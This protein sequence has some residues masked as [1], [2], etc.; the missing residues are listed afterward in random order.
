MCG[1][2]GV[3]SLSGE[4]IDVSVLQRMNDLQSHRGPDGE[5]FL[6]GWFDGETSSQVFVPQTAQHGHNNAVQVALGHRRLAILDLLD[7][8]L[9]PMATGDGRTWIVFNGEIYNHLELRAELE[10]SGYRFK[11][12]TDTEVLLTAYVHWGQDCLSRIEGMYAFAIWDGNQRRLF[13]ARDR[14]GIKPFYYALKDGFFIFASEI[15]ALLAFP[16][17]EAVAD[18]EAVLGFLTHG[19]CDYSERTMFRDIKALPGSHCIDID[20]SVDQFTPR[21][22]YQ[23]TPNTRYDLSDEDQ[24]GRLQE[25]LV[26]SVRKH[27]ISDVRIGS[28]L[29]GGLDSSAVV[30][31]VGKISRE[32][33]EAAGAIGDRLHTFT[34]CYEYKELD[35]RSFARSIADSVGAKS[36][37]VF[38]SASDFWADFERL[39][40]HQDMPCGSLSFYAQWRVMRAAKEAGVKVLLDGQGGDEVFGGYAKFRYAYMASLLRSGRLP[41]LSS[42]LYAMMR[43]GD[44]YVLDLRNG[45]RYLPKGLRQLLNVD[46]VMKNVIRADWSSAVSDQSSPATRWWRNAFGHRNAET[47]GSSTLMQRIQL[48]DILVDTL[49]QLLRF[50][51]R[52]SMAFS[53]EARVPL[54]DHRLVE[55]GISLPDHLKVNN[56]WSKFAVRKA[57]KG[58]MPESVRLRKSKLGFAAP[59]RIWL[60]D[61]LKPRINELVKGTMRSE[62]YINSAALRQWHASSRVDTGNKES[63]LGLFR[64][65]SLE[66]WMRTFNVS[67]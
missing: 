29:S 9:Q 61:D 20:L 51:D 55:H 10:Q 57:M 47:N 14:F 52:S 30:A 19:N 49:P 45:Y 21:S 28:C 23:L 16:G 59:D 7:R 67:C 1:I 41:R 58:L 65:M 54:L 6:L 12:R 3:V 15:K 33:P 63:Y 26:D 36:E 42:E 4:P 25:L 43:Q 31:L 34:S 53:I 62:K 17:V 5:G 27:L 60:S 64:I 50:E 2:L 8:G 66:T 32:N 46:S 37:L 38:P 44:R 22:Y 40:W 24:I 11:S 56:G 35:E 13:C 39:T 48:D 18:D